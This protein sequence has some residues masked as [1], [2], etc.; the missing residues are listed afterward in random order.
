M[1]QAATD[2]TIDAGPAAGVRWNLGDLYPGGPDDPQ[3]DADLD[4]ALARSEAFAEAYRGRVADLEPAELAT[5]VD[6]LEAISELVGRAGSF[7]GLLFAEDTSAPRHGA[8]MQ[9]V[10]QRSSAIQNTLVFFEL[11]WVGADNARAEALLAAP[12]L[13]PRR[14]YLASARR[15]RPHVLSE[16]EE[17]IA[18]DLANTGSR[19][20]NRL[21]DE[22]MGAARFEVREGDATRDVS[23]EEV[24]SLLYHP[25]R[26]TRREGARSLSAGLKE[27]ERVLAYIFNVLT[28]DKATRDRLRS[29]EHAKRS[30]N[31]SNE[32]DDA[33]VEALLAAA[34]RGYPTV[35]RYYRLK[36]KLLGLDQLEDFDRYAPIEQDA[37]VRSFDEAREIVLDA[38]GR[39]SP[40]MAEIA[41]L[42]FERNWVDAELRPG[43]RGGAFSA[44]TVP[45]AHP[46]VLLNYTGNLRDVMT[47]AHEL[48][49]GVHQYLAR[50]QGLFEQD[51]PL[52]TAETASVFGEMLVFRRLVAEES[53]PKVR[54]ALLCGKLEDAFATVSRQVAMTRFEEALH[55]ARREEGEL[56]VER[57]NEL[58]MA[59]NRAMFGDAV[60]LNDHYAAW[61][62]YIPHFVH[63]PF[64]CYAYAFGELLVLALL[65]RY[66]AEGEAFVPKY[67]DLLRAGGS[68]SP[69]EL[70]GRLGLD[71]TDPTFWDGGLEVLDEMVA[72]AEAIAAS[73]EA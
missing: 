30:R 43:K 56:P 55:S 18:E 60:T 47:V 33:T 22:V 71:I 57:V 7:A 53:D 6:E 13:S 8:L 15:Y 51:T 40:Q 34:E 67:L 44:S 62:L 14:H 58:W 54:L 5:A 65:R 70:V 9:H 68:E 50:D 23:E 17:K 27:N 36:A 20:F 63:S 3:I 38:Y 1:T 61:W 12:E 39:F 29:Y 26:E 42:F 73:L 19:A 59:A 25:E 37:N 16:P 66:D 2:K 11:E 64:Y 31:L 24:L 21:F 32:I 49:H 10:Q 35:Q 72:E 41:G 48:G 28:Q 46:Y 45:S 69:P 4:G 52:T